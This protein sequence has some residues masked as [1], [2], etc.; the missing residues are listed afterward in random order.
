MSSF[1]NRVS[2]FSYTIPIFNYLT[3]THSW[4][5]YFHVTFPEKLRPTTVVCTL[6]LKHCCLYTCY[7][8]LSSLLDCRLMKADDLF[9]GAITCPVVTEWVLGWPKSSF[10]FFCNILWK[11]PNE[12]FGQPRYLLNT[13]MNQHSCCPSGPWPG[14]TK[15][16]IRRDVAHSLESV[17]MLEISILL[18][19]FHTEDRSEWQLIAS[20]FGEVLSEVYVR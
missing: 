18:L 3:P 15:K 7:S 13:W 10:G 11:N 17:P 4:N 14:L 19:L 12:L 8:Y 1:L 20:T 2:T 6:P 9:I 5:L 16:T